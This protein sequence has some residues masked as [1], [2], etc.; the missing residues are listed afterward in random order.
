MAEEN[1]QERTRGAQRAGDND[2]GPSV[3]SAHEVSVDRAP[4]A[5]WDDLPPP[6]EP[7]GDRVRWSPFPFLVRAALAVFFVGL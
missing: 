7:A 4:D 2:I 1:M 5:A 6:S 3:P